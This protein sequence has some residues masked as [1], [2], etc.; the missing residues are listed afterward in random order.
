MGDRGNGQSPLIR[1][2]GMRRLLPVEKPLQLEP[3]A[4]VE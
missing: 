3:P 1:S 4:W 2:R